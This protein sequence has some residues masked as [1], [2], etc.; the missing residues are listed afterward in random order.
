[1]SA[2]YLSVA[3]GGR[4]GLPFFFTSARSLSSPSL[5]LACPF[6]S[7]NLA[8]CFALHA[9][10]LY[11]NFEAPLLTLWQTANQTNEI[12]H[13]ASAPCNQTFIIISIIISALSLALSGLLARVSANDRQRQTTEIRQ[14]Y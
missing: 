1:M 10:S 3:Q 13:K 2:E 6:G 5:S 7:F 11:A 8:P 4:L 14:V 12:W 9:L